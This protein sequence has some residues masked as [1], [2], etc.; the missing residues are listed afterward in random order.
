MWTRKW[1]RTTKGSNTELN[2]RELAIDI[3]FVK[4]LEILLISAEILSVKEEIGTTPSLLKNI[5]LRVIQFPECW[6]RICLSRIVLQLGREELIGRKARR[7]SYDGNV[8]GGMRAEGPADRTAQAAAE[9]IELGSDMYC[10]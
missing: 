10:V 9:D 2:T 8:W 5:R 7:R 4:P 6:G 3:K 1:E